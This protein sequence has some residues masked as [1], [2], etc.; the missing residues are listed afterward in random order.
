MSPE[1]ERKLHEVESQLRKRVFKFLY[2]EGLMAFVLY[3]FI[4]ASC[5]LTRR[6]L[7]KAWQNA[8]HIQRLQHLAFAVGSLP[9]PEARLILG[10]DKLKVQS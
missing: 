10:L 3:P 1:L 5:L 2:L 9:I 8:A 6:N 4:W 7:L